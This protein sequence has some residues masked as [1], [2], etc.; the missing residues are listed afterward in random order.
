MLS[1]GA[2]NA[3]SG[4]GT[5]DR[6]E[7]AQGKH[8]QDR[9]NS[10]PA[11]PGGRSSLPPAGHFQLAPALPGLTVSWPLRSPHKPRGRGTRFHACLPAHCA[12]QRTR[13]SAAF[14]FAGSVPARRCARAALGCGAWS[15]SGVSQVCR[16]ALRTSRGLCAQRRLRYAPGSIGERSALQGNIV[17]L[18]SNAADTRCGQKTGV[19]PK[20]RGVDQRQRFGPKTEAYY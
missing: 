13:R 3:L 15:R 9:S 6:F 8:A 18:G 4:A 11:G 7:R 19:R 2:D 16:G 14:P 1:P 17:A 10:M 5:L 12:L 20:D